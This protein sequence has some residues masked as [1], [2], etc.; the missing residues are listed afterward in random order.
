VSQEGYRILQESL[1]NAL[2]HSGP[3]PVLV[4]VAIADGRLN[5]EVRNPMTA[6]TIAATSGS[7]LRGIRERAALLGGNAQTGPS[8]AD[9]T[10]SAQ[11]P[12]HD[13][14]S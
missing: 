11:L 6:P 12:L 9:W 2:R 4:R 7:G 14:V 1:T 3:V 5:L 8:G 10:V 13:N